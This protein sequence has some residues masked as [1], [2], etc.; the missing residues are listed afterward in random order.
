LVGLVGIGCGVACVVCAG[1]HPPDGEDGSINAAAAGCRPGGSV[2]FRW[3]PGSEG[4]R[5]FHGHAASFGC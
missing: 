5:I 1:L 4:N 2:G 3:G